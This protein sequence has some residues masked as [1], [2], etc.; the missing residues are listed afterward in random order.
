MLLQTSILLP[1]IFAIILFSALLALSIIDMR[2][3]LLPNTLTLPL[4]PIGIFQGW[5]LSHNW[6]AGTI[7]AII[8]YSV[9]VAIE[10]IFKKTRDK[11][12]LGRGDAKLLAAGGAWCGWSAL[13]N[14]VLVGSCLGIIMALY[15]KYISKNTNSDSTPSNTGTDN[16]KA[17][18]TE[19]WIPFGPFLA[20]AIFT[21]WLSLHLP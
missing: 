18:T 8:G 5:V 21:I 19:E 6:L 7:G 20:F 17:G 1:L 3:Y 2:S 11:D 14:I 12:G 13:P 9:F 10:Y 16:T 4:I 15:M